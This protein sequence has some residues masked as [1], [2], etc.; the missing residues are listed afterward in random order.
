MRCVHGAGANL[1]RGGSRPCC[2][3]PKC[4]AA[5]ARVRKQGW[6]RGRA[7]DGHAGAV[8]WLEQGV[9]W[10]EQAPPAGCNRGWARTLQRLGMTVFTRL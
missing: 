1:A 9:G 2:A 4:A 8:S 3:G 6:R 5:S 7:P 10:L